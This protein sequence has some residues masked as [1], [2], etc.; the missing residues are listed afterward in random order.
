MPFLIRTECTGKRFDHQMNGESSEIGKIC[1]R[2][3]TKSIGLGSFFA[4]CVQ[5]AQG[6]G[7]LNYEEI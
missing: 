6:E 1:V 5:D 3:V 2:S 4:I 7:Q